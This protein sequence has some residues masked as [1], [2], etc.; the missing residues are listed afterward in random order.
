MKTP[1]EVVIAMDADHIE[2]TKFANRMDPGY[3][4]ILNLILDTASEIENSRQLGK[5]SV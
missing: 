1:N 3:R 5:L 2:M 4:L